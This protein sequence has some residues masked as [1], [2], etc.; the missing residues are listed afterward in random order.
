[1]SEEAKEFLHRWATPEEPDEKKDESSSSSDSS[2]NET[3]ED[4]DVPYVT[5]A[6]R[7]K[8]R[9]AEDQSGRPAKKKRFSAKERK[10]FVHL[11]VGEASRRVEEGEPSP[12]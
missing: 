2:D 11:K 9:E 3:M 12:Q 4:V 10:R 6:P 7:A 1:M 8:R 5:P